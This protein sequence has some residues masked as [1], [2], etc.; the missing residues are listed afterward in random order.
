[1]KKI[2]LNKIVIT[3]I[4]ICLG[5]N[6]T[7]GQQRADSLMHYLDIA[8]KNNP[9]V[10][11]KF[12]EYKAALQKVPQAGSLP[13]PELNVGVFLKP[14]ELLGGSQVADIKLMQMFPWF[15]VLKNAKDEMS[16]MAKARFEAFRD[17]GLQTAYDVQ[18]TWNDL[19][20]VRQNIRITQENITLLNTIQRLMLVKFRVASAGKVNIARPSTPAGS[21]MNNVTTTGSGMSSMGSGNTQSTSTAMAGASMTGGSMGEQ[22][23]GS[24]LS[25]LYRIQM[26]TNELENS[27][28]LLQDQETT[29]AARF[30]SYLNRPMESQVSTPEV[31]LPDSSGFILQALSDTLLSEN[32]MLGMIRFEGQSAESRKQM[33]KRMGYPMVGIGVDYAL[34]NK[35]AMSTSPMNG[36]DMIMPMISV[37]LPIYRK[38]YKSMIKEAELMKTASELKY[39]ATGNTLK[40]EYYAA[41]QLYRD[42]SRRI[43]LYGK[44][45]NLAR[46]SLDI[47]TKS[48][49]AS[50]AG[51]TDLLLIRR[52]L[53][54]Y[55]MKEVEAI[56]D[57]NTAIARL[58]RL[59]AHSET[60]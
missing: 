25:D 54:D 46:K 27:L 32:P 48:F 20:K 41:M 52:Q 4:M 42:A 9:A 53:L 28:A 15:G 1:M 50:G 60:E 40:T 31:L 43:K 49:S 18:R 36:N 35:S 17:A 58:K 3:G 5:L 7:F 47:T 38:K 13:D 21:S 10:L 30:N 24:G 6:E 56:A 39:Q 45:S 59:T 22:A 29:I 19:E 11:Q 26:E 23:G 12:T 34:I 16:L 55:E 44:Q 51:L 2:V 33:V 37:T 8:E 14:M 57:Y